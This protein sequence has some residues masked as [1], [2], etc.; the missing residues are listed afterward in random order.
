MADRVTLKQVRS[1]CIGDNIFS[2]NTNDSARILGIFP[3]A[4]NADKA[5]VCINGL[6]ITRRHPVRR[7]TNSPRVIFDGSNDDGWRYPR[8]LA[9]WSLRTETVY[10]ILLDAGHTLLING[11]EVIGLAHNEEVFG[12]HF[13]SHPCFDPVRGTPDCLKGLRLPVL[14]PLAFANSNVVS[15]QAPVTVGGDGNHD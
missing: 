5:T 13:R 7:M 11:L 4:D 2:P 14:P 9:P 6:W 1:L 10:T 8:D 15:L 12:P 3:T